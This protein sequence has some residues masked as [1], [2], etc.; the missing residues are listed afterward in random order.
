MSRDA[1]RVLARLDELAA[2]TDEPGR[3]TRFYLGPAHRAAVDRIADWMREAGM[4][5]GLDPA[6]TL[7]GR[8][9]GRTPD[10]PVL[11]LG[12]HI[13]TVRDAGRFDGTLGVVLAI[14]AVAALAAQGERLPFAV[15]VLAFGDE[16]GCRFPVTLTGS[17]AIAG[18]FDPAALDATDPAGTSLREALRQFGCDPARL[19]ECRR[20][21]ATTLG[22]VEAHIEQGP[23]LE[24]EDVPVGLV[25]GI[26]GAVRARCVVEG[27]AGHAGT[28]P[29]KL[30]RDALAGAAEMVLA[31]EAA[32]RAAEDAVA[33]VGRLVVE[34]GVANVVPGRV[35][36]D[37]DLRARED[38]VRF[39][40]WRDIAARFRAVADRRGLR[41]GLERTH[42]AP[43]VACD[44]ALSAVLAEAIR[45][46]GLR[47][48]A[49]P[50]GAGHDAMAVAARLPVAMLFVRC[51]E[52]ISHHP[53]ESVAPGDVAEALA[54]LLDFLHRLDPAGLTVRQKE[55]RP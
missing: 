27:R 23:V 25:T 43:A 5:V 48:V 28:V 55:V 29:M 30:R 33:T 14:E 38:T 40:L 47:L 31:V 7:V 32:A 36:F 45:A 42:E 1:E 50:S 22:Y 54:V 41:L 15:E 52:G 4:A 26:A 46:R 9:P 10:A 6:A 51:R 16:E 39:A 35:G 17:R 20:D 44:P 37:L 21:P 24:A 34:P 3:L 13:D 12:S 53:D 11:L 49:L 18:T 19:G 2:L 8:Y